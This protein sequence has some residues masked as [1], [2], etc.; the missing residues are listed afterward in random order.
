M[1]SDA[2]RLLVVGLLVLPTLCFGCAEFFIL[3]GPQGLVPASSSSGGTIG[4]VNPGGSSTTI[5]NPGTTIPVTTQPAAIPAPSFLVSLL[6]PLLEQTAGPVVVRTADMNAD[7]LFDFVS[8]SGESQPIQLHLRNATD[9]EYTTL[10]IAG[11]GPIARMIDLQIVDLDSDGNLDVAVLINDTGFVPVPGAALRGAVVLLFAPPNPADALLWTQVTI[12]ATFVLPEDNNSMT[13]FVVTDFDGANG[14]DIA[15]LS[16]EIND[17]RN[18][19]IYPNPGGA[20]ARN[21]ANWN[22]F[23]IE[24]DAVVGEALEGA[25]VDGDGDMDLVAA[26]PTA[27]SFNLRWLQN[28]LVEAGPGAVTAGTWVRH[29]LGQQEGG[30]NF[31]D[32]GDIDGD[33]DLDV[34]VASTGFGL[35]QWFDNPGPASVG[36][37]GFPWEVYNLIQLQAGFDINQIQLADLDLNGTLDLYVTASGNIVGAQRGTE[38]RDY[39]FPFNVLSTDPVADIGISAFLDTNND[40]LLDIVAP[41]DREGLTMDQIVVFTRQTP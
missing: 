23:L 20:A 39:W 37:Q 27:K 38:L 31:V 41:L 16:N 32:V 40:G 28:P 1:R 8:G 30:G 25:D 3:L 22:Q 29:F 10:S 26:F 11:G 19:Y 5:A 34:A 33:G 6:D 7:G 24:S 2:S 4:D 13:D 18:V 9:L 36:V 15:L 12:D 21:G 17:N 35:V 14:P